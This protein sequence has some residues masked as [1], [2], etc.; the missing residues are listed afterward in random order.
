MKH[1]AAAIKRFQNP[2][3][4]GVIRGKLESGILGDEEV[5]SEAC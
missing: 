3:F 5:R 1:A 2:A 4:R